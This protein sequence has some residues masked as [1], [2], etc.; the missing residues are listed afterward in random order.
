MT[1]AGRAPFSA[2]LLPCALV[3]ACVDQLGAPPA[4]GQLAVTPCA[5]RRAADRC[6]VRADGAA[7]NDVRHSLHRRPIA[8]ACPAEAPVDQY[9][10]ALQPRDLVARV[11]IPPRGGSQLCR[12]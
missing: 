6:V 7:T 5:A 3:D 9:P 2:P 8:G 10:A 11:S 1:F 4:T 12:R